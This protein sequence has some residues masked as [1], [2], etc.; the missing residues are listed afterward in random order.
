MYDMVHFRIKVNLENEG[1]RLSFLVFLFAS[2][3]IVVLFCKY[4]CCCLHIMHFVL[5]GVNGPYGLV[6][7]SLPIVQAIY[8]HLLES[9]KN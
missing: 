6:W 9:S 4:S 5:D 1:G 8:G 2:E 3:S 7:A